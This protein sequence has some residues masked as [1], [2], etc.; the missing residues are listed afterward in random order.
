VR[1]LTGQKRIKVFDNGTST[2][3]LI[4]GEAPS[5]T[6]M[7]TFD[8]HGYLDPDKPG[9]GEIVLSSH[10]YDVLAFQKRKENYYQD[11]SREDVNRVL[12]QFWP[13]YGRLAFYG[14]SV[15]AYAALYFG[16]PHPVDILCISPRVSTH[17]VYCQH[18]R[19]SQAHARRH[20][21]GEIADGTPVLARNVALIYDPVLELRAPAVAD[22]TYM[23][24]HILP[25]FP[26]I[27]LEALRHTG[28][29]STTPLAE[30]HQLRP[31][32]FQFLET[33]TIDTSEYRRLRATSATYL[34]HFSAWLQTKNRLRWAASLSE[35]ALA[36]A[37][38]YTEALFQHA[39]VLIA[40]GDTASARPLA[41]LGLEINPQ[42]HLRRARL[43]TAFRQAGDAESAAEIIKAALALPPEALPLSV[44]CGLTVQMAQ[45]LEGQGRLREALH[46]ADEASR[47]NESDRRLFQ[48]V[49]EL[50]FRV[51]LEERSV[52]TLDRPVVL[53]NDQ[54]QDCWLRGCTFLA[55]GRTAEAQAA[56]EE[57]V[58][59]NPAELG[60]KLQLAEV[61]AE[62]YE[63][64]KARWMLKEMPAT[65]ELSAD[66]LMGKARVLLKLAED[67]AAIEALQQALRLAPNDTA[68]QELLARSYRGLGQTATALKQVE[69]ALLHAPEQ[70]ALRSLREELLQEIEASG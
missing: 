68:V 45:I 51:N 37:P 53:R 69:Q 2:A 52:T 49:A 20:Q 36:L 28:H 19:L 44:R 59:L 63:S 61:Y 47:M 11:L 7:V 17:P 48:H 66:L 60:W 14:C 3:T 32:L 64:G 29:P 26:R 34:L 46:W 35:R 23:N 4:S 58:A 33:G 8:P 67:R 9:F 42:H 6:L 27:R 5:G 41:L 57:A 22:I 55:L 65:A 13:R 30:T 39:H 62:N 25:A 40:Q 10:G 24:E 15:G 31:L 50:A 16:A 54:G 12:A 21:H 56:L 43:I 1:A 38:R 70:P 18:L